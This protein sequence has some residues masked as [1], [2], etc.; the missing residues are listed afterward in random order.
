MRRVASWNGAV[1]VSNYTDPLTL[2]IRQARQDGSTIEQIA[3]IWGLS[4][5]E[6]RTHLQCTRNFK[7]RRW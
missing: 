6:V 3:R 2:V 5:A 7:G 4:E 1:L